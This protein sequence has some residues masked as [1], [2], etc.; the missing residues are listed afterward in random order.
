MS[1]PG[2]EHRASQRRQEEAVLA[3]TPDLQ[4]PHIAAARAQAWHQTGDA[5]LTLEA[6][7]TWLNDYGL[8]LFA[9]RGTSLG[10]PA[11]SLVEATLGTPKGSVT[12][13]E[14]EV[15][16][17]LSAR[18]VGEGSALP[19]NLFGGPGDLPDFLASAQ[20]FALIFTL[21][22]DKGWKR[23]P[24]TAGG[25]KVTPLGLRVYEV[26]VEKGA[27]TV[28]EI[29]PEI[30]REVTESAVT[31]ALSELWQILRVVPVLQQGEGDTKWELTTTRFLKAVKAGAN[32]GQ[33]TALSGLVSL[34]LSQALVASEE[35]IAGFL[36]PL[37]ARSRVREVLHGLSA[38]KQLAEGVVNGKTVLYIPEML[39]DLAA[40]APQPEE[41]P[42]GEGEEKSA[43][44]PVA[45]GEETA[46]TPE[47]IR[48]FGGGET[49]L[50]DRN[51]RGKPVRRESSAGNFRSKSAGPAR[52]G[53]SRGPREDRGGAERRPFSPRAGQG[54]G[55]EGAGGTFDR[56]RPA[57]GGSA[58]SRPWD[59]ERGARP[60]REREDRPFG[61][62]PSRAP[63]PG[64]GS[65][66]DRPARPFRDRDESRPPRR[67]DDRPA[68]PFPRRNEGGAEGS[69][70]GRPPR[71]FDERPARPFRD[72]AAEGGDRPARPF[73]DR[74]A[75]GG[76]RP[77]RPFRDR[78]AEGGDRPARPFR[79]RGAEGGARPARPF[80]D[81]PAAGGDRPARPFRDRPAG[82]G[83]R[84]ARPFRDRP[85][86][87]GEDRPAR[88]FR[89]R[90]GGE[91]RP[92]RP[93]EGG[94]FRERRGPGGPPAGRFGGGGDRPERPRPAGGARFG[95]ESR[96]PG[97]GRRPAFGG[98]RTGEG[99]PPRGDRPAGRSG[100]GGGARGG[101][102]PAAKRTGGKP[103]NRPDRPARRP[104]PEDE[105]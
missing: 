67:F 2:R 58:F 20:A 79:D 43:A 83:D 105:A 100:E 14:T 46:A 28:A 88:P 101:F 62:R 4:E 18:L 17:T 61:D 48:R 66:E 6:A 102:R 1:R 36:S 49:R 54:G 85:A 16:R 87:G 80:R 32:A 77:A 3:T 7:R 65:R 50:E 82:G 30:G 33:P 40:F 22:G 53:F 35:E 9:P 55:R 42:E 103:P 70:E 97:A 11:P 74:P 75:G 44:E 76:D 104:R 34:Y 25:S 21:R 47:R 69:G 68:R 19:L 63:R 51:L 72:R 12:A 99:R 29:V 23:A 10:A 93:R 41:A 95:G 91:D 8:V 56:P 92:F 24:E 84:P 86:A 71:R 52:G 78:G 31:R 96:G 90:S 60:P 59:E 45:E 27:L 39:P 81:R 94:G 89:E 98:S 64:A 15:A 37:T 38:G 73:R 57:A 5:L 26:L 13:A